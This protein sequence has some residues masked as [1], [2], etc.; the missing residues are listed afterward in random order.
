MQDNPVRG[1]LEYAERVALR[2]VGVVEQAQGVVGMCREHDG[3]ESVKRSG[4][5]ADGDTARP[6]DDVHDRI[7]GADRVR[8]QPVEDAFHV[9]HRAAADCAP[10]ERPAD[11]DQTVMVK[12]AEEVVDREVVDPVGRGGPDRGRD[13]GQEV[14]AE[15]TPELDLVEVFAERPAGLGPS[16]EPRPGIAVEAEHVCEHPPVPGSRGCRRLSEPAASAAGTERETARP[17]RRAERH[18][19]RLGRDAEFAEHPDEGRI[20]HVVVDDEPHVDGQRSVGSVHGDGLDVPADRRFR[21]VQADLV[22]AVECIGGTQAAD[23]AADDRDAHQATCPST[24]PEARRA[25]SR[26]MPSAACCPIR[27]TVPPRNGWARRSKPPSLM[28]AM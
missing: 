9:C 23:P 20:G 18:V 22:V 8:S 10:L 2:L 14:V 12:K 19:A 26:F 25:S 15:T 28:S 7:P 27:R 13:R 6:P 16:I 17:A 3:V 1:V 11:A 5:R 24:R 4:L 21:V